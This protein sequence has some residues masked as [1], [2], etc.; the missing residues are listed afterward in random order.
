MAEVTA[1]S[2]RDLRAMTDAPMME[3]KKALVEAEGNME[4]AVDLLRVRLGNKASKSAARVAA[5]GMI[6]VKVQDG[7]AVLVE[8]NCE[9]DFVAKDSNFK[10]FV[11]NV[12]ASLLIDKQ[13]ANLEKIGELVYFGSNQSIEI[14]RV[15][16]SG[17]IGENVFI[18]RFL[19]KA[20]SR[21]FAT[22]THND[23]IG[24]LVEYDGDDSN[25]ARNIA[26]HIAAMKPI[27]LSKEEISKDI[28]DRERNVAIE[29]AMKSGKT[30]GIIEKMVEGA[31]NKF[32]SEVCLLDQ[33]YVRDDSKT[34]RQV[35]QNSKIKIVSFYLY[36]VGEGIEKESTNF[37]EEVSRQAA[38]RERI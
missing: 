35:T 8:V 7:I 3:C 10:I 21:K 19:R 37:V 15:T 31:V 18:R 28:I 32:V 1:A 23:R 6:A 34:I 14:A 4:K 22:Y 9:T 36:V 13:E 2:V 25:M 26:M 38:M 12:A 30:P 16:L 27:A 5:E 17:K 11:E 33:K 20:S 29:K 24:V